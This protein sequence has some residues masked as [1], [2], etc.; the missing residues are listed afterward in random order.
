MTWEHAIWIPIAVV[1]LAAV[2]VGVVLFWRR[3]G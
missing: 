1:L 3:R 2:R